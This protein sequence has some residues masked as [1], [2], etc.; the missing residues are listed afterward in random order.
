M[1]EIKSQIIGSVAE[2]LKN[3]VDIP[4]SSEDKDTQDI[5][6]LILGQIKTATMMARMVSDY[7]NNR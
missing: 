7:E 1:L 4:I 3:C 6:E 2:L 5:V